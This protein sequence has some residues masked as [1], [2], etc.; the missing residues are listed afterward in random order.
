MVE[1]FPALGENDA[2]S[3]SEKIF[4]K[5]FN[6]TPDKNEIVFLPSE[7]IK[8]GMKVYVDDSMVDMSFKNIENKMQK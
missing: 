2:Y 6:L 1:Y 5:S 3:Q 4:K 7:D 8:G